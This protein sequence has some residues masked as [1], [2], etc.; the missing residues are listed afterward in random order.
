ML[1]LSR[2]AIR[3]LSKMYRAVLMGA[4]IVSVFT[5]VSVQAADPST[6]EK[7]IED[8]ET[9]MDNLEAGGW[10]PGTDPVTGW[11]VQQVLGY[12][13][14]AASATDDAVTLVN[15]TDKGNEAL[16]NSVT[17]LQD[18]VGDSSSGLVKDVDDLQTAVGDSSSGLVKDVDDLQT[19]VGDSSSGLVKD[20]DDLQT[21]VG[22][23]SSGLVKDVDD[24]KTATTFTADGNYY[25]STDSV[26]E[27]IDSI[28]TQVKTNT[29]DITALTSGTDTGAIVVKQ[30]TVGAD[31][32]SITDGGTL[33]S[34]GLITA[35][36]GLTVKDGQ[37]LTLGGNSSNTID[38]GAINVKTA[39]D[40]DLKNSI[41]TAYTLKTQAENATYTAKSPATDRNITSNTTINGAIDTL[42]TAIGTVDT[43]KIQNRTGTGMELSDSNS[44]DANIQALDTAIGTVD[45]SKIQNRTGTGMKLSDSNSVDANIQALDTAIGTVDT[46]K[47]QNRTGTGMKLS[48]SNSVDANIQALDTAIGTVDTSKIQDRTGTGMKLS[49]SNS[50]DANIQ[51]LD[52]TIGSNVTSTNNTAVA[53]TI[54]ANISVLDEKMGAVAELGTYSEAKGNLTNG[55]T[56]SPS[57]VVQALENIDQSMGKIHKLVKSDGSVDSTKS[58]ASTTGTHSNL[59]KG[60]T[61]EDHLISLDNA[62]GNRTVLS[63]NGAINT[64]M[65]TS[66]SDGLRAAGDQIGSLD[67]S[68]TH[69]VKS[70]ESLTSAISALDRNLDRVENKVKKLDKQMKAGFASMAALT[71]LKPNARA[72]SD[73]Q[74]A[75][76][77]GHYRGKTGFALGGFHYINDNLMLNIG[78]AYAGEQS[79]TV[80]G[81]LT[82]GW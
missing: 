60:T 18:T 75:I 59:A 5:T 4:F 47:I 45:T 40:A 53:N 38:H 10:N 31:G 26:V 21:T 1:K 14:D 36:G 34:D 25:E 23:S 28:D 79:A 42:D 50:V 8:T 48:D 22:D 43:S 33:T 3:E 35:N 74:I 68:S 52:T 76:G 57:T 44:V 24:L 11:G 56:T 19:T 30:A 7:A 65:A 13:A 78:A 72:F 17:A 77:A 66:L 39:T 70:G 29:D 20:V 62:I 27:A 12:M 69:Y 54:N 55:T 63:S 37:N 51:A 71:G 41:A 80:S 15:S 81:G 58:G 64:G 49:A 61:V 16:Y 2:T 32:L 73:T 67:Y 9:F 46:S 82:F 6:W